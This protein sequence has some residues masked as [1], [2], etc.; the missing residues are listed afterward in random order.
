MRRVSDEQEL[1]RHG[2]GETQES[3][4]V[5]L[6]DAVRQFIASGLGPREVEISR[7][8]NLSGVFVMYN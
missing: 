3:D 6:A 8:L 2:L 4:A 7:H 1:G 5:K